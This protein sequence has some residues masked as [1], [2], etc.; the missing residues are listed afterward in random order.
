MGLV[1]NVAAVR[2]DTGRGG[3]RGSRNCRWS[4]RGRRTRRTGRLAVGEMLSSAGTER[5]ERAAQQRKEF[6]EQQIV[7]LTEQRRC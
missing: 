6:A 3:G 2:R 5:R 7:Q 4:W 1:D